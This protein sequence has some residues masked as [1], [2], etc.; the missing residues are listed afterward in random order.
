MKK[1]PPEGGAGWF[2]SIAACADYFSASGISTSLVPSSLRTRRR[3]LPF[4]AA[5]S[6]GLVP[7][8]EV[9]DGLAIDF[10][11]QVARL[12]ALLVGRRACLDLGHHDA[13]RGPHS[14]AARPSPASGSGRTPPVPP[15]PS[16]RRSEPVSDLSG[17]LS[18][19]TVNCLSLSVPQDREFHLGAGLVHGDPIH[20]LGGPDHRLALQFHDDVVGL[21]PGL[22]GRGTLHGPS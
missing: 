14:P 16:I 18:R 12:D 19:V 10:R 20:Q 3:I 11:D 8:P 9:A 2:D 21:E 22:L 6:S 1:A 13:R 7:L 5:L 4:S 17:R 15:R